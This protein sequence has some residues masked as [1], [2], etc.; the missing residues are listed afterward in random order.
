MLQFWLEL[1]KQEKVFSSCLLKTRQCRS[2]VWLTIGLTLVL[3]AQVKR[4][5]P[6]VYLYCQNESLT[7]HTAVQP[8][9]AHGGGVVHLDNVGR[10]SHVYLQHI[11][12][13]WNDLADH[14]LFSQD[15]P[16]KKLTAR[17]LVGL[18]VC[19]CADPALQ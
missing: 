19:T 2:P 16:E 8:L 11:L 6:V 14:T 1:L 10:E 5:K 4:L 18:I 17:L 9:F 13:H 12:A 3:Q 7:N 15:I